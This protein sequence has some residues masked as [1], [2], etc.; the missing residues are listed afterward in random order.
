L[1]PVKQPASYLFLFRLIEASNEYAPPSTMVSGVFPR[2]FVVLYLANVFLIEKCSTE[3]KL[4]KFVVLVVFRGLDVS[5]LMKS[6]KRRGN[7]EFAALRQTGQV[8]DRAPP[9]EE[10]E[11]PAFSARELA[12]K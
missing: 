8:S 11:Y 10:Q 5:P 2:C 6:R 1:T 9:I 4:L 3:S 7:I 12:G